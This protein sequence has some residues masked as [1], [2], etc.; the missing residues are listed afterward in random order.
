MRIRKRQ[1]P[2]PLSSLS[3]V[4]I[5]VSDPLINL[6]RPPPVVVQLSHY[7]DPSSENDAVNPLHIPSQEQPPPPQAYTHVNTTPV[8][9][10][11]DRPI[12]HHLSPIVTTDGSDHKYEINKKKKKEEDNHLVSKKKKQSFSH[13][14]IYLFILF[15]T[16]VHFCSI[17]PKEEVY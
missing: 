10:P 1:V 13:Y 12:S 14:F 17:R 16:V 3:P 6:N 4:P 2:F 7:Y 11:S 9:Q 5:A 15:I 8:P